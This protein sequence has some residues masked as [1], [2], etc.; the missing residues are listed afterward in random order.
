MRNSRIK[1]LL[2]LIIV[3]YWTCS[4]YIPKLAGDKLTCKAV[5]PRLWLDFCMVF[6][7]PKQYHRNSSST[8][9]KIKKK[10]C[11]SFYKGMSKVWDIRHM[12][13]E[14][15]FSATSSLDLTDA[16]ERLLRAGKKPRDTT[17]FRIKNSGKT[18]RPL[19]LISNPKKV[20]NEP[21][22]EAISMCL[23]GQECDQ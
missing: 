2:L 19:R 18:F 4:I 7:L 23:E 20:R 9:I 6:L 17:I 16:Q 15:S 11:P 14:T 10:L 8:I 5:L 21:I 22:L 3:M 1:Y 12:T 13:K